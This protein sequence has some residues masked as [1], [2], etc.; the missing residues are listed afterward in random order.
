M[1]INVHR[2][3][4]NNIGDLLSSPLKYFKYDNKTKVI[5]ICDAY[6]SVFFTK[7]LCK[8]KL[9]KLHI[10]FG[11][12]GLLDNSYFEK[13]LN[14]ITNLKPDS[15]IYW[16]VG[17]NKHYNE[18]ISRLNSS[19][20]ALLRASKLWGVR[21]KIEGLNYLPCSSCM[22]PALGMNLGLRNDIVIY[23][24]EHIPLSTSDLDTKPKMT[25][26]NQD[27]EEVVKFLGSANYVITNSYHGMYWALLLKKKVVA[28]P[29]SNKFDLFSYDVPMGGIEEWSELL[30]KSTIYDNALE[31]CRL[32]N[33]EFYKK[34]LTLYQ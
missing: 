3:S 25:N 12:G 27:F 9:E 32:L 33:N 34:T 24:H 21:D 30:E 20:K 5:D 28:V 23:E 8:L 2:N 7:Y 15:I 6:K 19:S 13:E 11:G 18:N 14:Y 4:V 1:I 22:H 17:H 29:F 31:E 10:I 26:N 16:G